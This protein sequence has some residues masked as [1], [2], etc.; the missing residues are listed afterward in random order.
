MPENVKLNLYEVNRCGYFEDQSLVSEF[1]SLT[2]MLGDLQ[3]WIE[4][5]ELQETKTYGREDYDNR[6]P[7]YCLDLVRDDM[8]G[9]YLLTTWNETPTDQGNYASINLRSAVGQ[10]E[11]DVQQIPNGYVPGY[12]TY[13]WFLSDF[14]RFCTI[15]FNQP[16]NGH[17]NLKVFLKN[18]LK[19]YSGWV[20]DDGG[21]DE[22]EILGYGLNED[23]INPSLNPIFD[24]RPAVKSGNKEFLMRHAPFIRKVM[25][26]NRLEY[27]NDANVNF[28]GDMF[29]R[30]GMNNER[31][32]DVDSSDIKFEIDMQFTED[33]IEEVFDY[34]LE[35]IQ[36][37]NNHFD[38][39]GFKF[40]GNTDDYWLSRI[41]QKMEFEL[42][43]IRRQQEVVDAESL[44]SELI[45]N[46]R[47]QV[48]ALI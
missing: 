37:D 36:E 3:N 16:L 25:R 12:A 21:M 1:C 39:I 5:K 9:D 46:S 7:T 43:V 8:T 22:R 31:I 42:D 17:P 28:I 38:D 15:R 13:F 10:Y 26:K 33:E 14:N 30:I 6:L 19:N 45:E 11:L 48:I 40:T 47:E 34:W 2:E 4:G 20:F 35:N 24:S 41:I 23:D 18:Y 27:I 44:L 32:P 29:R